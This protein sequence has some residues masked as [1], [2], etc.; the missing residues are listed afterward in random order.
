MENQF[1]GGGDNSNNNFD[2]DFI[3][4]TYY[5]DEERERCDVGKIKKD[6]Q[7]STSLGK[8]L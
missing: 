4:G 5:H 8:N 1:F 2:D 6:A 3:S 7:F